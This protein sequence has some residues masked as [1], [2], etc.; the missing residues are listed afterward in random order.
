MD[1]NTLY[2]FS[3]VDDATDILTENQA[4]ALYTRSGMAGGTWEQLS[5]KE[6][7]GWRE[8]ARRFEAGDM[9]VM[10]WR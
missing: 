7:E 1:W 10:P 4:S 3:R 2:S 9:S 6:R 5:P 8:K